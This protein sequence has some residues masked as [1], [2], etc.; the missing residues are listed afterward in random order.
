M[1]LPR[2]GE[3]EGR[4]SALVGGVEREIGGLNMGLAGSALGEMMPLSF[5]FAAVA[6]LCVVAKRW[7]WRTRNETRLTQRQDWREME[8]PSVAMF[9]CRLNYGSFVMDYWEAKT[10]FNL[11]LA[12]NVEPLVGGFDSLGVLVGRLSP[13]GHRWTVVDC[14]CRPRDVRALYLDPNCRD[15]I[16]LFGMLSPGLCC[17]KCALCFARDDLGLRGEGSYHFCSSSPGDSLQREQWQ[18]FEC[19]IQQMIPAHGIQL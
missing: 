7:D 1:M 18:S 5:L 16:S 12:G 6:W 13:M 10:S 19:M 15:A 8:D 14:D 4:R 9:L 11:L 3:V 17:E 2:D